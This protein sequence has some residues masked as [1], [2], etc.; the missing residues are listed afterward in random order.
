[1]RHILAPGI[2]SDIAGVAS[3]AKLDLTEYNPAHGQMDSKFEVE[4]GIAFESGDSVYRP[5][6]TMEQIELHG[7]EVIAHFRGGRMEGL[8]AVTRYR[9]KQGWVIYAATDSGDHSF[10][11]ALAQA[12]ANA[13]GLQPLLNVPRGVAVTTRTDGKREFM[14]VLNLTETAHDAISLPT[15]ME[16]WANGGRTV[17]TLE[18][19]PLGVA[20]LVTSANTS[21]AVTRAESLEAKGD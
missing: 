10:H 12:A 14:F 19:G 9:H 2:F 6:T 16:D 3:V 4:L 8:P 15:P 21:S 20:L 7:A 1:M 5:R 11:E 18:L 13:V 17:S